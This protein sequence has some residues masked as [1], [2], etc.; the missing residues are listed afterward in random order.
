MRGVFVGFAICFPVAFLV[1]FVATGSLLVSTFA[2]A[3]IALVVGSLLGFVSAFLGC[4]N[5]L[6]VPVSVAA[7][8]PA[9]SAFPAKAGGSGLQPWTAAQ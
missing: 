5:T 7:Q 9:A 8:Q 6:K 3:T 2:I 4:D 1:L